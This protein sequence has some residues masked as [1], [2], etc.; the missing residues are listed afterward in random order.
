M[1]HLLFS[2]FLIASLTCTS[3][4]LFRPG[5]YKQGT[6][7]KD[8]AGVV[9]KAK[10]DIGKA[11]ASPKAGTSWEMVSL[12]KVLTLDSLE[13][14]VSVI[15][16]RLASY[17]P[18][19]RDTVCPT[20]PIGVINI[21]DYT[22]TDQTKTPL[23]IIA[24][25][26]DVTDIL[27]IAPPPGYTLQDIELSVNNGPWGVYTGRGSTQ[28]GAFP[29][30]FFKFRIKAK[31]GKPASDVIESPAF[32]SAT[33]QTP[34]P[35]PT[36]GAT[37]PVTPSTP[38][39]S[40][41]T[42]IGIAIT[43]TA[44]ND[45]KSSGG[46]FTIDGKK[47]K[48]L[49]A[50][51]DT[52]AGVQTR[53]WDGTDDDYKLLSAGDYK[54]IVTFSNVKYEWRGVIGN[55]SK[56]KTG[57]TIHRAFLPMTSLCFAGDNGFYTTGYNE[58]AP[59][60]SRFKTTSPQ[61]KIDV[62]TTGNKG[63][64]TEL[65]CTDGVN[66]YWGGN[67]SSV[68]NNEPRYYIV[69]TKVSDNSEV[70][71]SQGQKIQNYQS[72]IA[73]TDE[74]I[75]GMAVNDKYLFVSYYNTGRVV[76]YDKI[77][78]RQV[79]AFILQNASRL[80][81]DNTTL[82]AIGGNSVFTLT[83]NTPLKSIITNLVN[84]QAIAL[85]PDSKTIL[86][87][88]GDPSHLVKAFDANGNF[89]WQIG[90]QLGYNKD[91]RVYD[92][93]FDLSGTYLAFQPDG[94]FWIGDKLNY[95]AQHFKADR[96]FIESI[97]Y[98]P[99]SYLA[100]VDPNNPKRV[101]SKALEFEVDYS[102][103]LEGNN[104]SWKL[105][106]NYSKFI[107]YGDD[108]MQAITLRNGRCYG[109]MTN[110]AESGHEFTWKIVELMEDGPLRDA[111]ND[112]NRYRFG[113]GSEQIYPN[114]SIKQLYSFRNPM[115]PV[116]WFETP[117]T[118]FDANNNPLWGNKVKLASSPTITK[119]DPFNS[120]I[121]G[122]LRAGEETS[123]GVMVVFNAAVPDNDNEMKY[124]LGGVKKGTNDWLFRTAINTHKNYRG[125]FPTDGYFDIGNQVNPYGGSV[126]L[127]QDNSIYWNYHGEFWKG[128]QANWW[129]HV[130][131]KGL[132]IGQFGAN[133]DNNSP[134]GMTGNGF[135]ST[136]AKVGDDHYIF[137]NDE[138]Y[139][140]GVHVWKISNLSS[141]KEVENTFSFNPSSSRVAKTDDGGIDLLAGLPFNSTVQS[142]MGRLRRN[143]ENENTHRWN[144]RTN[145]EKY[146]KDRSP[147]VYIHYAMDD[148]PETVYTVDFDL[149]NKT[150]L[151]SWSLKGSLHYQ[152]SFPNE[153]NGGIWL[154]VLDASGKIISRFWNDIMY[155][156]GHTRRIYG[157]GQLINAEPEKTALSVLWNTSPITI[158]CDAAGV[159][160]R[161]ANYKPVTTPI[162][163][164]TAN[165]Q[166]PATMRVYC[167]GWKYERSINIIG[168]KFYKE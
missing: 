124:H 96:T 44:P 153:G 145:F 165:W 131:D 110:K 115:T 27:D 163:D 76:I 2:I 127:A 50:N 128:A 94:S 84:P 20:C 139:H 158:K 113:I 136:I 70:I 90:R 87:A 62:F 26:N 10:K 104:G 45:C 75:G 116:D 97:M 59:S 161:Y 16:K 4:S 120:G 71:F 95:R 56:A 109:L 106:K 13:K 55:T 156:D 49:W 63:Q 82:F 7:V 134:P 37:A 57:P 114:G 126:V 23:P 14:R 105:V 92:D 160:F 91:P 5:A 119:D 149:G 52:K 40:S 36:D 99:A 138:S 32:T 143:P 25:A 144:V 151:N 123:S 42:D 122:T 137:Q 33:Q 101:F 43:F 166:A 18:Q 102:K 147:D 100:F 112:N 86:V 80:A 77:S 141:I 162:Y 121:G 46:I 28:N 6:L 67:G 83:W 58:M 164:N 88:E 61:E 111:S 98:I 103:P 29:K 39:V 93:K 60:V 159:T 130:T 107:P 24:E 47:I 108:I 154:E 30:G 68:A 15:E 150:S 118:G 74:S 8:A 22:P 155:D 132:T 135:S 66:V 78:G 64:S 79:D 11:T 117:L 167:K 89:L 129:Q 34:T 125:F 73:I 17:P 133:P 140:S 53:Y 152:N 148:S 51:E 69:A 38:P 81:C 54:S 31:D 142:G 19:V 48:E 146:R 35:K 1:K 157:N 41:T 72:A 85:S 9:W 168:M 3:Q 65:S 12:T 21:P